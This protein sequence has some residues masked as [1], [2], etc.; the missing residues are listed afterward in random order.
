MTTWGTVSE[1]QLVNGSDGDPVLYIDYPGRDDAFLFDAG[2]L[3]TLPVAK[4]A[5]LQA[6]FLSHHHI[7]HV[8]SL[9]RVIRANLDT[10]K[11]L[12]VMGPRGTIQ[13][14]HQRT[15]SY[16]F[17]FFPFMQVS[18]EVHEFSPGEHAVALL[19]CSKKFPEP[20]VRT[21][22]WTGPTVY[23]TATLRVEAACTEHTV[24]GLAYALVEKSGPHPDLSKLETSHLRIGPWV[25]D[26][27]D[28]LRRQEPHDQP[29]LIDGGQFMLGD[30][31]DRY[32]VQ[33]KETRITFITDTRLIGNARGGLL[34][35][36]RKSKLLFCDSYYADAQC[37]QADQHRHATAAQAAD[38]AREAGAEQLVLMH[39]AKRYAGRYHTLVA[40][41]TARFPNTKAELGEP[42]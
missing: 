4:L 20:V 13:K 22:A 14:F 42:A 28:R 5:D 6:V 8:C 10:K 31:V 21:A 36:A 41:A 19:E 18:F 29:V 25:A 37:R 23:E 39:F 38:F 24:P 34:Q 7:D 3:G 16:D 9:D 33:R 35:L 12:R 11:C 17:Q 27:L 32:F 2:E 40:E 1:I 26:V 15:T 30:L